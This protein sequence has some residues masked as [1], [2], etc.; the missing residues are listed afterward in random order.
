[1]K[2]TVKTLGLLAAL[3]AGAAHADARDE[4]TAA[5]GKMMEEG[6][7]RMHMTADTRQGKVESTMD[8]QW[9][10]RFR[11]KHD[12]GEF[13]ILP[14]GTW[15]NAGGQWMKVPMNMS[16]MI[17]GYSKDAMQKGVDAIQ[18][19]TLLGEDT[20]QGCDSKRYGYS[21]RGE[22]MGVKSN[23]ETEVWICQDNGLPVQ[24]VS[25]ERGKNDTV[26]IV[27]DW[28]TKIDIRAPN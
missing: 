19:V 26:R 24:M 10:D 20:V 13:I 8:V 28:D 7:Y 16:Q 5:F 4:V 12:S 1:M 14:A 3:A 23:S 2:H 17:Q 9:P 22:F 21:A 6:S 27:Y 25:K 11:M 18:E 15:M